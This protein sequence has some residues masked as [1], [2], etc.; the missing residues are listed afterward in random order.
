M[1]R[2]KQNSLPK[3]LLF[4]L[5]TYRVLPKQRE[6]SEGKAL[7]CFQLID[8][9]HFYLVLPYLLLYEHLYTPVRKAR[10]YCA[11]SYHEG[12]ETTTV[13]GM[14]CRSCLGVFVT[15]TWLEHDQSVPAQPSQQHSTVMGE[16]SN[17]AG[18]TGQ[19]MVTGNGTCSSWHH[20][21]LPCWL[22]TVVSRQ[23]LPW[24][25][26]HQLLLPAVPVLAQ[27]G[28]DTTSLQ[29]PFST[30]TAPGVSKKLQKAVIFQIL[31]SRPAMQ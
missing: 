10:A 24:L 8:F 15:H 5:D 14:G 22:D 9:F 16:E 11:A 25:Q 30:S 13:G 17:T 28:R 21:S 4:Y 12:S 3:K 26:Q 29:L 19:E 31:F 6:P 20:Q 18:T 7:R 2:Q 23:T 27:A 1:D